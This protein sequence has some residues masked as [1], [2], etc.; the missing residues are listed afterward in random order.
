MSTTRI[1]IQVR[2]ITPYADNTQLCAYG[3]VFRHPKGED[4]F[5]LYSVLFADFVI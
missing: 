2:Y 1:L 4:S 3:C 5:L